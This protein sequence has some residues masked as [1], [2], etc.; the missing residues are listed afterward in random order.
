[1]SSVTVCLTGVRAWAG[2][3]GGPSAAATLALEE[4]ESM[5]KQL[6]RTSKDGYLPGQP[7]DDR[8]KS[9]AK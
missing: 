6:N 7:K 9:E 2:V 4:N 5:V 8:E 1:M 3:P